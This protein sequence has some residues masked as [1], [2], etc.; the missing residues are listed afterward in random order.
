MMCKEK[1][2]LINELEQY[3]KLAK[4]NDYENLSP[5]FNCEFLYSL[6]DFR[7]YVSD[8]ADKD[9]YKMANDVM[10]KIMEKIVEGI[11]YDNL[12]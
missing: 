2:E 1:L 7:Y 9:F 4:E 5:E 8:Q 10:S 6:C 3:M 12:I 11:D